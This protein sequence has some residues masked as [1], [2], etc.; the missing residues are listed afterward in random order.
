M[1]THVDEVWKCGEDTHRR[2]LHVQTCPDLGRTCFGPG[3]VHGEKKGVGDCPICK[4][5]K[6]HPKIQAEKERR[7]DLEKKK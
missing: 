5:N 2:F 7:K 4:Q 6:D 1:C 3:G